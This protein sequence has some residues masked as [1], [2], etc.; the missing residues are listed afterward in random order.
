[1][2]RVVAQCD[3]AARTEP[4]LP[5]LEGNGQIIFRYGEGLA[6][7]GRGCRGENA[8]T[9]ETEQLHDFLDAPSRLCR[10]TSYNTTPAATDT[11]SDGTFPSIGIETRKS[12]C[13]RTKSC[14]PLPSAPSTTAQFIL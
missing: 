5:G 3:F 9:Q 12:Q 13:L 2:R 8:D 14:I 4:L 1:M 10:T 11:F 6:F 7:Q